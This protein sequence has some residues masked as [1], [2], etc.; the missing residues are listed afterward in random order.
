LGTAK[1]KITK[2]SI[3]YLSISMIGPTLWIELGAKDRASTFKLISQIAKVKFSRALAP[4]YVLEQEKEK[5]PIMASLSA[6][7]SFWQEREKTARVD[8]TKEQH[9]RQW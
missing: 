2:S 9:D 4:H 7:H 5:L 8:S 1:L 6:P 3:F